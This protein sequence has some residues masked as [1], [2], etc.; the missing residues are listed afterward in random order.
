M[1]VTRA[2]TAIVMQEVVEYN[3]GTLPAVFESRRRL[4]NHLRARDRDAASAEIT[5]HLRSLH[6]HLIRERN[7][8]QQSV[9]SVA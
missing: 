6:R 3:F 7:K 4:I 9:Q 2:L 5:E 1:A 8:R